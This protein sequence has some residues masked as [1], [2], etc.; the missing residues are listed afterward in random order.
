MGASVAAASSGRG[1]SSAAP[2]RSATGCAG[3]SPTE[4]RA[5]RPR[6]AVAGRHPKTDAEQERVMD[7]TCRLGAPRAAVLRRA[8]LARP[9]GPGAVA[10]LLF[11]EA[12]EAQL[13]HGI[14]AIMRARQIRRANP[15]LAVGIRGELARAQPLAPPASRRRATGGNA[16]RLAATRRAGPSSTEAVPPPRRAWL[17]A[18]SSSGARRRSSNPR[19]RGPPNRGATQCRGR[20]AANPVRAPVGRA[21]GD[22]GFP[23]DPSSGRIG[24]SPGRGARRHRDQRRQ[25]HGRRLR[26]GPGQGAAG[27]A[28]RCPD[29][30]RRCGPSAA[31]RACA[32]RDRW[33]SGL[34]GA[35]LPPPWR[36]MAAGGGLAA[37]AVRRDRHRGPG[38]GRRRHSARAS[39][40]VSPPR[41]R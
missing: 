20:V 15:T 5:T 34:P 33:R 39:P 17:Q 2:R 31:G 3:A 1:A 11:L 28:G 19:R 32:T 9:R 22:R 12:W 41:P 36:T 14:A 27:R 40:P 38:A 29:R 16:E 26:V 23:P 4:P 24:H 21:A 18:Q 35:A 37:G 30:D 25:L 6:G 8:L 10:D 7:A 13:A